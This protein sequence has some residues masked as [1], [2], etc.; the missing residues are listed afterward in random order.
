MLKD[1]FIEKKFGTLL[2]VLLEL[3][4]GGDDEGAGGDEDHCQGEECH[5]PDPTVKQRCDRSTSN[6]FSFYGRNF[7]NFLHL[8]NMFTF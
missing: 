2:L 4:N 5:E 7:L 3:V 1:P 6:L 8:K